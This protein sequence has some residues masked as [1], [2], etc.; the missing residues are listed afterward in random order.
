MAGQRRGLIS[1]GTLPWLVRHE[2]RLWLRDGGS[3]GR[4]G[5]VIA[6]IVLM[7]LPAAL[8][9]ALALRARNVADVPLAAFGKITA[10][11][12]G[13]VLLMLSGACVYVLRSFHDRGDLDL[14][15]AAPLPVERVLAAKSF[16]IHA[17]VA[18]PLL[19]I[20]T[21][22]LLVSALLGHPGWLGGLVMIAVTAVVSTSAAFVITGW[23]FRRVGPRRGR[24]AIQ[25]GGGVFAGVVAILAQVPNFAPA[26]F[27][28]F[29][30]FIAPAPPTPLDW[31]AQVVFGAPLPLLAMLGLALLAGTLATRVTARNLAEASPIVTGLPVTGPVRRSAVRRFRSGVAGI[32]LTKELRLLGRDPEL[33]SSVALQ[34]AY[35]IPAFALIFS[36]VGV[37]PAR[38]AAACVL[39]CGLLASSL[40]WLTLCAEDAPDLIA[41]APV[42]PRLVAQMKLL[43]AC[44]P[45]LTIVIVPVIIT[46]AQDPRAGLAAVVFSIVAAVS[47]ALQQRWAGKPQRRKAFRF[48][49]QGSLL[50]AIS[51]F[52]MAGAWAAMAAL[53]ARGSK[54]SLLM[55]AIALFVLG[56]A[57]L[58]LRT[59]SDE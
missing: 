57:W 14:L 17:A 39:F 21:P 32:L 33:L 56:A 28:R 24:I 38:L 46:A 9:I 41:A 26:A 49:Q 20:S 36:S 3:I 52:S 4:A 51:E 42:S 11:N 54:W 31:P 22:F 18:T 6:M 43:A 27:D 37:L 34:L 50:L 7:L 8:G 2:M 59:R 23:L 47:A 35:M 40:G 53:A 29:Q 45:P 15:L 44:L 16:A 1:A 19:M 48:R 30:A 12:A 55:A 5:R 58:V 25:I 13:L 10:I